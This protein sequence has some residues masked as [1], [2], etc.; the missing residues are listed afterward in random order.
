MIKCAVGLGYRKFD[1]GPLLG[2]LGKKQT[3]TTHQ[4]GSLSQKETSL[5]R[6]LEFNAQIRIVFLII[7]GKATKVSII[8]KS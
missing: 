4:M 5:R 1:E 2:L 7:S 3:T 8:V 6:L